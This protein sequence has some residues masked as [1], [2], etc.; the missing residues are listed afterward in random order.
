MNLTIKC[1]ICDVEFPNQDHLVKHIKAINVAIEDHTCDECKESF[2][3]QSNLIIHS[4][5]ACNELLKQV[6]NLCGKDFTQESNIT[7]DKNALKVED[8][9][10][11]PCDG[12]FE[13]EEIF[14][15][16]VESHKRRCDKCNKEFST[17]A[18]LRQ[19]QRHIHEGKRPVKSS[20]KCKLCGKEVKNLDLHLRQTHG[21]ADYACELCGKAFKQKSAKTRHENEI[22][23]KENNFNCQ[24]CEAVF[25]R[26]FHLKEH[27]ESVHENK[28]SLDC[29]FCGKTFLTKLNRKSHEIAMHIER[30]AFSCNQCDKT[31]NQRGNLNTH[32]STAHEKNRTTYKCE[33]CGE[34]FLHIDRH[35][36]NFH[37]EGKNNGIGK[38]HKNQFHHG[39]NLVKPVAV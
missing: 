36:K 18:C 16:H 32:V 12:F 14:L 7:E 11:I 21:N 28:G 33:F 39:K 23:R 24:K 9:K 10:C 38:R 13:T 35:M 30:N 17:R 31:F 15:K 37:K 20:R 29:D 1:D 27:V 5:D 25:T 2:T 6:C 26:S 19:H 22:H 3:S 8:Y 4:L 34:S